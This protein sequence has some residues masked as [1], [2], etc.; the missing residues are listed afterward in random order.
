MVEPDTLIPAW[1]AFDNAEIEPEDIKPVGRYRPAPKFVFVD[2]LRLPAEYAMRL[3]LMEENER[4]R[5]T[6]HIRLNLT[7]DVLE[8]L[9]IEPHRF[10]GFVAE[11]AAQIA[12]QQRDQNNGF[13]PE[14]PEAKKARYRSNIARKWRRK[15]RKADLF[16]S[17]IC[18]AV[19]NAIYEKGAD[20]K[21]RIRVLT[22]YCSDFTATWYAESQ[23]AK[24][25]TMKE[26][27]LVRRDDPTKRMNL[28]KVAETAAG[29][30]QARLRLML[31][32]EEYRGERQ[33]LILA[34]ITITPP[35]E[36]VPNAVYESRR[37]STWDISMDFAASDASLQ[38]EW[39]RTRALAAKHN[40][41]PCG[42]LWAAQMHKNGCQHR[43][44]C[45]WF[46]TV[47]DARHLCDI[48]RA[49][50]TSVHQCTAYVI[51]D[52][53]PAYAP[54][55]R[56][57]N[58][59][60]ETVG[61]VFRYLSRYSHRFAFETDISDN[62]VRH[63]AAMNGRGRSLAWL[64]MRDGAAQVWDTLWAAAERVSRA[65][66]G[67]RQCIHPDPRIRMAVNAFIE[68]K[69]ITDEITHLRRDIKV[70]DD[71]AEQL[72]TRLV[73]GS[74]TRVI[75]RAALSRGKLKLKSGVMEKV[76]RLNA[77]EIDNQMKAGDFRTEASRLKSKIEKLSKVATKIAYG[78]CLAMGRWRD[79]TALEQRFVSRAFGL[80][81]APE[82]EFELRETMFGEMKEKF[83]G[84]RDSVD[85]SVCRRF[86][87]EWDILTEAEAD[88][89]V[90]KLFEATTVVSEG[91]KTIGIST[92]VTVIGTD[93]SCRAA[94]DSGAAAGPPEKAAPPPE[95]PPETILA[96]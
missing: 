65:E 33:G 52:T 62:V 1:V 93:P 9:T 37:T 15:I 82:R 69:Q 31:D 38:K 95:P 80:T 30:A 8:L 91:E 71:A 27:W 12:Q 22:P 79:T 10:R 41:E 28:A 48:M 63:H 4:K 21:K 23:E 35:G 16:L 73:P 90:A 26:R 66:D 45:M 60:E 5:R 67:Y 61:T 70:L 76:R 29:A 78:A 14:T 81:P 72:S 87:Y 3:F 54:P 53:N 46:K 64:G 59:L 19:G 74:V 17:A 13:L 83:V 32:V 7:A 20:G 75:A 42:G 92:V 44:M 25:E 18:G 49:K 51:G 84:L 40:A 43:H 57:D 77:I 55:K 39:A 96:A 50:F 2:D 6:D 34:W 68:V 94:P 85:H 47:E 89:R 56:R 36:H 86:M 88:E 24:W 58:G 11:H